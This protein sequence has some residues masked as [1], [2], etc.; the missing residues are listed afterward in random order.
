VI[1]QAQRLTELVKKGQSQSLTENK[2]LAV[3]SGKGGTGKSFFILN[4]AFQ[5]SQM[6]KRVLLVDLD[7]NLA[8]IDVM[9][10][11]SSDITLSNFFE[12]R[13]LFSEL[14][15]EVRPNLNLIFGDSGK[16]KQAQQRTDIIDYLFTNIRN[17]SSNYD[18][19]L[20]DTGAGISNE[21]LYLLSK[22]DYLIMLINPDPTSVMDGYA[23]TKVY[24]NQFGKT[25]IGVV[26]NK[27]DDE[28]EGKLAF[29]N[30]NTA[31]THF[32]K[33][34]LNYSGYVNFNSDVYKSIKE[35]IVFS[36]EFP[37]SE[38][39]FQIKQIVNNIAENKTAN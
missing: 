34:G 12:S 4:Y 5:L 10:N 23:L 24:K 20:V 35:Q 29:E 26:V 33:V 7:S 14:I 13:V 1:G 38:I 11:I 36:E 32:L 21:N 9:L 28:A 39:C 27:C 22:T 2:I 19:I 31:T 6:G 18:Y 8:N 3:T 25:N 17:I 30:L 16:L 15:T 37:E